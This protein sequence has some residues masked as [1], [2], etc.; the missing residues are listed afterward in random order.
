VL[1]FSSRNSADW[2][3]STVPFLHCDLLCW[4]HALI[5]SSLP[6]SRDLLPPFSSFPRN[7]KDWVS[8]NENWF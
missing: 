8:L 7:S 1:N 6:V 2:L 3:Q 5:A 4:V